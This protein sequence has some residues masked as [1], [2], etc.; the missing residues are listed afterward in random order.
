MIGYTMLGTADLARA[1]AFYD[2]VF[3]EI[4]IACL[5]Q[6]EHAAYWGA[7]ATGSKFAV[8][9]PQNGEPASVGNGTMV[10]VKAGS[11]QEVGALHG[12]AIALGAKNEGAV[13]PR[14]TGGFYGGYFRDLDGNKVAVFV[15]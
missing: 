5:F 15:T 2:A 9:R 10:A 4:G 13:G 1:K 12:K 6:D 7:S 14:G 8:T 11:R 3:A